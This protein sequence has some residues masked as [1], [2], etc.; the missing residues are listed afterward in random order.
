MEIADQVDYL[1]AAPPSEN[2]Y[3]RLKEAI[4]SRTECTEQS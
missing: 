1:L 4:L 3:E 2:P